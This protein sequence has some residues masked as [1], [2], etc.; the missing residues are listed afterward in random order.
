[1]H[2]VRVNQRVCLPSVPYRDFIAH[3]AHQSKTH[4][5]EAYFT[6]LLGD[7]DGADDTVWF[8]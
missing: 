7:I 1:M 5:A 4:D 8:G 3:T 6:N 2:T